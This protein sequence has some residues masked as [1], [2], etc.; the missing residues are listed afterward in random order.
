MR[1][2]PAIGHK[3]RPIPP[4]YVKGYLKRSKSDAND[5]GRNL[6]GGDAAID[7]G[8]LQGCIAFAIVCV[9]SRSRKPVR[10]QRGRAA[11]FE[12]YG[13]RARPSS[14]SL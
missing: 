14:Q 5:A 6:R 1:A 11:V 8:H 13:S 10:I 3:V 7:V 12:L 9:F 2:S 4:S